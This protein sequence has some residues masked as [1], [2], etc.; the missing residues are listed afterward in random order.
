MD[1]PSVSTTI[2]MARLR[3]Y[4]FFILT[5]VWMIVIF[6]FSNSP[7]EESGEI[8]RGV[9]G[10]FCQI[11]VPGYEEM[12][13]AEQEE[14]ALLLDHPIRKL[15]HFMEY[16]IL[17][18]LMVGIPKFTV[19]SDYWKHGLIV[20]AFACLYAISD[21]IHQLF[22]PG[23]CGALKDVLLDSVGA[24]VGVLLGIL[25]VGLVTVL[26]SKIANKG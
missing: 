4:I 3:K 19:K 18:A 14:L 2:R 1:K 23:R 26:K 5:I 9:G 15:A 8:S 25:M 20:W 17:G 24:F 7:G 10:L 16:M 22:V 12:V 21:E 11:F 13:F 6:T